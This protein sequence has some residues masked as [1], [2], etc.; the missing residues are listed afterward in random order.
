MDLSIVSKF[1]LLTTHTILTYIQRSYC[2][3]YMRKVLKEEVEIYCY[4]KSFHHLG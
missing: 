1:E 3:K 2:K 4:A